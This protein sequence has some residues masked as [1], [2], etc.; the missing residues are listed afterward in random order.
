M[1]PK[2][3]LKDFIFAELL[4]G[5]K[6]D[7]I[8]DDQDLLLSGLVDSLGVVRMISFIEQTMEVAIP[9]EDVTLENFQTVDNIVRYLQQRSPG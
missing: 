2:Q 9:P 8:A 3:T 6:L 4:D 1:D 5:K 7:P